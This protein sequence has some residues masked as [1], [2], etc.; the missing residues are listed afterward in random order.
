MT[1]EKKSGSFRYGSPFYRHLFAETDEMGY[2]CDVYLQPPP[3]AD[4]KEQDE[5]IHARIYGAS[6]AEALSNARA[7]VTA[8]KSHKEG[9]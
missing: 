3:D 9:E 5:V 1:T 4:G 6:G 7:F 2:E 8:M